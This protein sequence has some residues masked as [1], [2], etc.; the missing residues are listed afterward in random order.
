MKRL[1]II[2]LAGSLLL[3][4]FTA[5]GSQSGSNGAPKDLRNEVLTD[6]FMART[7]TDS[8]NLCLCYRLYVPADY[9]AEKTYPLLVFLHG[10][11]ERGNDNTAQ[12][13]NG[14]GQIFQ[15]V[16][17]PLLDAIIVAPQCPEEMQW[18]DVASW[19]ECDYS[20]DTVPESPALAAVVELIG[21]LQK[22]YNI[23][24]D[25]LY[26]TGISMGGYGTWDLLIR[27]G[28]LFAA[29]IPVCGGCDVSKATQLADIPIRAFHG[30][31]DDVVPIS[32][33]KAMVKAVKKAGGSQISLKVYPLKGHDIWEKAYATKGLDEWLV[34]Q[35]LSFRK[36]T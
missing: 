27:H 13:R 18:V 9:D 32:G 19:N 35:R 36:A 3:T 34:E 28:E 23:D 4:I 26:A 17:S 15:K 14:I 30:A 11:G 7:F 25:R 31:K 29:A 12:L 10:A 8:S 20:T 24:P 22:Q 21:D 33:I 2:F 5:C 6:L 1:C 16:G